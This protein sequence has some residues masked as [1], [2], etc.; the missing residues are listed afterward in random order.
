M[1][2]LAAHGGVRV[3]EAIMKTFR[4]K[5]NP[6]R[7]LIL[8]SC[9]MSVQVRADTGRCPLFTKSRGPLI[10]DFSVAE[11]HAPGIVPEKIMFQRPNIGSMI[12]GGVLGNILGSLGGICLGAR[13]SSYD[14]DEFGSILLGW[15]VGSAFGSATG[16]SFAGRSRYWQG[17]FGMA[18]LGGALGVG[19]S[20]FIVSSPT[21]QE[22]AGILSLAP[23]L[24][25]P[26]IGAAL[27]FNWSMR[28]RSLQAGSGLLNL[29]EGRLGLG[30]PDIQV[31]PL[32]VPGL[33]AKPELQFNVRVLSVEL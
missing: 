25:L 28:S 11:P 1:V 30:V 33:D 21:F 17:N 16:V 7:I 9:F 20:W 29:A 12:M 8:I 3:L 22:N 5:T 23:V 31:R 2:T 4:N 13:M 27:A 6:A 24:L 19:L 14:E 10:A 26:P 18:M 32:F 15:S